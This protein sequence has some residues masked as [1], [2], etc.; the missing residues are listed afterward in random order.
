MAHNTRSGNNEVPPPPPPPLPTPAE[1][2]ATL[3]EGQQML[4][5]ALRTMAP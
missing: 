1:L 4:N 2:L 3:V 5:E